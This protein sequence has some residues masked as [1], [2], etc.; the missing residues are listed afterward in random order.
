MQLILKFGN[1]N[2]TNMIFGELTRG[3]PV[4]FKPL[5]DSRGDVAV[6]LNEG[7]VSYVFTDVE[8]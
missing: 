2:T 8:L 5:A 3:L 4:E 7:D 6:Q 1:I